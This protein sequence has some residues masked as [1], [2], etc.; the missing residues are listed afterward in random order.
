MPAY[1][2]TASEA[3]QAATRR[4][5]GFVN[6]WYWEPPLLGRY[7]ADI[8]TRL[9]PLA[10]QIESG[11]L[12]RL[13]PA[14]DF[15]GHN[16]YSRA[17]VRDDPES[18]LLGAAQVNTHNPK[19]AMGWEIYPD[20]LYDALV[21][22]TRDYGAPD[23]YITENGAAFSDEVVH[24]QVA[25]P[26]RTDYLRTHLAACHRAVQDGV[27]LRGYFCWSLLDNFEWTFGYG[28]RF[29]LIYTDYPTQ[30]RIVKASGRFF[31]EVARANA[32]AG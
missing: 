26:E 31:G 16:S 11:D 5:D 23:I 32:L 29:G 28:K 19:T 21:R 3:D 20:H 4:F 9:G 8:M 13:S 15:F 7:P 25:D 6:R 27:K 24:G 22:I 2:A 30:R 18:A 12:E 1:P 14:I 10:P 17:V